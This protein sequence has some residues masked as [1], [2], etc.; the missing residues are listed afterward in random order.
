MT[1]TR[2]PRPTISWPSPEPVYPGASRLRRRTVA[3]LVRVA[4][5][6]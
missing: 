5:S 1:F 3:V 4:A 2:L 6:L